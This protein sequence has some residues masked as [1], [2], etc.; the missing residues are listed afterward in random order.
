MRTLLLAILISVSGLSWAQPKLEI[1]PYNLFVSTDSINSTTT[2]V[3]ADM[4]VRNVDSFFGFA[5]SLYIHVG[6]IDTLGQVQVMTTNP[7][8]YKSIA[9]NDSTQLTGLVIS[10]NNSYF[11]EGNNT[12]VI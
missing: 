1:S 4:Y 9:T 5:D 8:G 3:S 2:V 12:V 6:V 7:I 10:I 11:M